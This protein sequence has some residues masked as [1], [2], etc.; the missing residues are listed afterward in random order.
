[1]NT[2]PRLLDLFCGAGGAAMGS[3]VELAWAAGFFD[4]EG[5]ICQRIDKRPGRTPGLQFHMEQVDPRPLLRFAA[6][7]GWEGGLS[8][9]APRGG[10]RQAIHRVSM[11]H[12][13]AVRTM[14]LLWPY[15]S[16]PKREQLLAAVD[17]I[18]AA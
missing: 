2:R 7:V 11:G 8:R 5:T 4:G 13:A 15:L 12:A 6:A 17:R 10:G 9:R 16:E 14:Q 1:M 18:E 3:E